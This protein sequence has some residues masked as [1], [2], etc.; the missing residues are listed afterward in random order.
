MI[1]CE[2]I[3]WFRGGVPRSSPPAGV[4]ARR[5][6]RLRVAPP[7]CIYDAAGITILGL[8]ACVEDLLPDLRPALVCW[9]SHGTACVDGRLLVLCVA[10]VHRT[11]LMV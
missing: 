8:S 1:F 10:V 2:K 6:S 3:I 9:L 11:G 7:S 4:V 5:R